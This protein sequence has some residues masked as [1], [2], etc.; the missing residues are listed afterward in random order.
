M[1]EKS[2]VETRHVKL[3]YMEA[4]S[5]K[6]YLLTMQLNLLKLMK[7]IRN[8][9]LL[10]KKEIATKN[11]L[12]SHLTSFKNQLNSIQKSFPEHDIKDSIKK[13]IKKQKQKKE[14]DISDELHEIEAKLR[15]LEKS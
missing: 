14:L 11:K 6:K 13:S 3:E 2:K 7:K 15:A 10:R 4:L 8:Y 1:A 9:R 5:A 12:K